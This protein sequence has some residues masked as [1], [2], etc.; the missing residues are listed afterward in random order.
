MHR[1]TYSTTAGTATARSSFVG[2]V[3]CQHNASCFGME[4]DAHQREEGTGGAHREVDGGGR[5]VGQE[6]GMVVAC[7]DGRSKNVCLWS[8]AT[9]TL[10]RTATHCNTLQHTATHCNTL[11]H[12]A[13]QECVSME[14]CYW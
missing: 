7:G 4:G 5:R 14:R 11:Q 13:T 3:F 6:G 9:G 10:Q 1:A 12:T 2:N 8:A